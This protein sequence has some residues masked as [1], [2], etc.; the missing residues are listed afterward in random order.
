MIYFDELTVQL[1]L[2]LLLSFLLLMFIVSIFI[3]SPSPPVV[4]RRHN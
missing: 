1:L 2:L 4:L 3:A